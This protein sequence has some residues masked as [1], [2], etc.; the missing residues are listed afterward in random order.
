MGGF[1]VGADGA[2]RDKLLIVGVRC[3][4]PKTLSDKK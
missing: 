2:G 3:G 1:T 4:P